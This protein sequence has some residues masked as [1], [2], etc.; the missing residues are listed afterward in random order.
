MRKRFLFTIFQRF[1]V[2]R[3][4][5]LN[6]VP[7]SIPSEKYFFNPEST[8]IEQI[9]VHPN[10]KKVVVKLL[11]Q[12]KRE[13]YVCRIYL[14]WD[15]LVVDTCRTINFWFLLRNIGTK[16][17]I[18]KQKIPFLSD[19]PFIVEYWHLSLLITVHLWGFVGTFVV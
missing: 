2:S 17:K 11:S 7:E 13:F 10:P 5:T 12:L 1:S 19:S 15:C 9:T 14:L 18:K 4:A 3:V 8:Y 16:C 6:L